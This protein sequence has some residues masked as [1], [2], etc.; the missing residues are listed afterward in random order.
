MFRM[1]SRGMAAVAAMMLSA[2]STPE[3]RVLSPPLP[4][5]EVPLGD[6]LRQTV[7]VGGM[8]GASTPDFA[9][10]RSLFGRK[11]VWRMC[12]PIGNLCR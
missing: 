10:A 3:G 9:K 7:R 5:A 8:L 11:C 12:M 4:L 1:V 6:S 2:L